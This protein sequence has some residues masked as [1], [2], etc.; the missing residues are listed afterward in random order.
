MAI[1]GDSALENVL[2]LVQ[3]SIQTGLTEAEKVIKGVLG[4]GY[5][6]V[7]GLAQLLT[8]DVSAIYKPVK[9]FVEN[10]SPAALTA[11][12][13]AAAL[14][15]PIGKPGKAVNKAA[16]S[17]RSLPK[18]DETVTANKAFN[19]TREE[20]EIWREKNLKLTK[21]KVAKE[22]NVPLI[23]LSQLSRAVESRGGAKIP[24]LSDLRE[25]GSIEQDADIVQFLYRPEYHGIYED[26]EGNSTLGRADLIVA[27]NRGGELKTIHVKFISYL[28]KFC[29]FEDTSF[30]D[31][32][33]SQMPTGVEF[34]S[35]VKH[36][37]TGMI[38]EPRVVPI[39]RLAEIV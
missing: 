18:V 8:P 24:Q 9:E 19:I 20:K 14:E 32:D 37:P 34:D 11:V 7:A 5:K 4:P 13:I 35:P 12:G 26:Y 25:S 15:S 31:F 28:T 21:E 36:I 33:N 22:L 17:L 39:S 16:R 38:M 6:P 10:P 30:N 1:D 2:N 29:D 27:K 3:S 23:A